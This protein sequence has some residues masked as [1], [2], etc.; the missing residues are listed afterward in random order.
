MTVSEMKH[1]ITEITEITKKSS[2]VKG[3]VS[4]LR[5]SYF[6]IN[7]IFERFTSLLIDSDK[8][9][10]LKIIFSKN[11]FWQKSEN[12]RFFDEKSVKA[13]KNFLWKINIFLS[14]IGIFKIFIFSNEKIFLKKYVLKKYFYQNRSAC[15]W[16]VQKW[17]LTWPNSV[18]AL[19]YP[20]SKLMIFGYFRLFL[21]S[22]T[23]LRI[24]ERNCYMTFSG[25][26]KF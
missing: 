17:G 6:M 12:F 16:N 19:R 20:S 2:N 25:V 5:W 7:L 10:F 15:S 3:W 1:E 13:N 11:I 24:K 23:F 8:N 26:W 21:I 14:K 18:G 22:D 4:E 9:I